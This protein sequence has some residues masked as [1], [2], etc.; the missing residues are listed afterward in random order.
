MRG[1]LTVIIV[2]ALA[3]LATAQLSVP[4]R[5]T[6]GE[7][8][9]IKATS[10]VLVFGPGIAIKTKPANGEVSLSGDEIRF[11]GKYTIVS[12]GETKQFKVVPGAAKRISFIAR[13]SRVPVAKP[14]V[15]T[16]VAFVFDNQ[17]NLVPTPTP[18]KFDLS[19]GSAGTSRTVT[20]NN[21][22]AW[23][24]SSSGP[25]EG[26]AQFVAAIPGTEVKR[27]VQQVASEPCTIRMHVSRAGDQI[28]AETDPIKDCTGNAV[29]DGTIVTFTQ[30]GGPNGRTTVDAR[31]KKGIARAMLPAA[32]GGT[33]SV[34]SGVVL[35]NEISVGGVHEGGKGGAK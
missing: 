32:N 13:P 15:I 7:G 30:S 20:S 23:I 4:E 16:G 11:I 9:T 14:D 26:A 6:A 10:G 21:G 18:V 34:A 2:I 8:I 27:V 12:G 28:V 17:Q 19:V 5:V 29:P 3:S 22:V 1:F 25:R 31:I 35:G 33:I 24:K